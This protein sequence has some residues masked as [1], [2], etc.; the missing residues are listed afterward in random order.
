MGW[1]ER[2]RITYT[3]TEKKWNNITVDTIGTQLAVLHREVTEENEK[4]Q[5]WQV[6]IHLVQAGKVTA[7][8]IWNKNVWSYLDAGWLH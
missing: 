8:N 4:L 3:C 6:Y 2:S 5:K 7:H 1:Q